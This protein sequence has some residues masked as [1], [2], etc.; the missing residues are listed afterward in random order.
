MLHVEIV[1]RTPFAAVCSFLT[2]GLHVSWI[3]VLLWLLYPRTINA[4]VVALR[5]PFLSCATCVSW[6]PR[7]KILAID[8]SAFLAPPLS[9]AAFISDTAPSVLI[10]PLSTD[11]LP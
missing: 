1:C 2:I 8:S 6:N 11:C 7:S 3:L 5:H 9:K 10:V 4:S